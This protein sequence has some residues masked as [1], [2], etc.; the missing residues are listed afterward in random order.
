MDAHFKHPGPLYDHSWTR[1][2]LRRSS[3]S[4][5]RALG[6]DAMFRNHLHGDLIVDGLRLRLSLWRRGR[7]E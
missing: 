1:A 2:L 6:H 4:K 7:P 5:E 3:S